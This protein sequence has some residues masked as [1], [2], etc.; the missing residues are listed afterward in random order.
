[1]D[2]T[3]LSY[4]NIVYDSDGTITIV[5][6]ETIANLKNLKQTLGLRIKN[7]VSRKI[8]TD[9]SGIDLIEQKIKSSDLN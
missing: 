2:S 5:T 1:M 6:Q 8:Y 4:E 7:N 9:N 3:G